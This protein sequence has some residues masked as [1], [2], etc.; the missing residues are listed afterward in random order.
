[1]KTLT[2]AAQE[3]NLEAAVDFFRANYTLNY[4][5]SQLAY[6][7]TAVP[8]RYQLRRADERPAAELHAEPPAQPQRQEVDEQSI[9]TDIAAQRSST[10]ENRDS[11][12]DTHPS[13]QNTCVPAC[14]A[15]SSEQA[16]GASTRAQSPTCA[17]RSTTTGSGIAQVAIMDGITMGGG[18]GLCMNGAFRVATERCATPTQ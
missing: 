17:S 9:S 7:S 10:R 15:S 16:A 2:L 14:A 18:V 1:M 5:V 3:G 6:G 12:A 8:P 11:H 13:S 4:L